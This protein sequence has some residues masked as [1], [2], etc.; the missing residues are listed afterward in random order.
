MRSTSSLKLISLSQPSSFSAFAGLLNASIYNIL[1][2][3]IINTIQYL[4]S[5]FLNKNQKVMRNRAIQVDLIMVVIT[6]LI[7]AVMLMF[8]IDFT[9]AFVPIFILLFF[10][11]YYINGNAHELYLK[12]QDEQIDEEIKE[13][14]KWVK[15]KI[16]III[17]YSIYLVLTSIALYI[18]GN[19]LSTVLENLAEVFLIPEFV[20]GIA[21]GFITS[22]PELI[23]FFESQR[24]YKE[25]EKQEL[26]V[27][28]ATN[29][30]LTSNILNLFVIQS[31][32]ILVYYVVGNH[33]TQG[34]MLLATKTWKEKVQIAKVWIKSNL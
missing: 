14:T 21:L 19:Q 3:N 27:V 29:N 22:L 18:I 31:I 20:L 34:E 24:H 16:N 5:I 13:E 28:E 23:T 1:S 17:K 8:H 9:I 12:K 15:G 25:K 7:P 32:G 30:L 26:G 11:F 4:F 10:L 2:S 6:I 33:I